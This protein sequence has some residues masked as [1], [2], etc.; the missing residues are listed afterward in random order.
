MTVITAILHKSWLA[1]TTTSRWKGDARRRSRIGAGA[2]AA[3]PLK[4]ESYTSMR[5]TSKASCAIGIVAAIVL[6]TSAADAR[7]RHIT[8]YRDAP[9]AYEG[10][11]NA[12]PGSYERAFGSSV[13][14]DADGPAY[15]DF[16][17]QGR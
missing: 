17:L 10:A 13:P 8:H 9:Y 4:P 1:E 16:Q 12:D 15:N 11:Y 6:A 7:S 14:Y 2:V 5:F 3:S